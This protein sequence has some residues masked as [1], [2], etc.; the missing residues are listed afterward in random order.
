[1]KDRKEKMENRKEKDQRLISR[2]MLCALAAAMALAVGLV[3]RPVSAQA[4]SPSDSGQSLAEVI[5]A[6]E[7]ARV[8]TRILYVTAHPD[9]EPGAVLAYLARGLHAD[10]ALLSLTRGEGGQNALGPEQAPQL[11]ILRTEELMNAT[12]VYGTRLFFTRAADFGYTKSPEEALK[13]WGDETLEDMVRVIR[14]F[15]PHVIINNWGGVR[16]GHGQHVAAGILTPKAYAMAADAKAFP[17]LLDEGLQPWK[18]EALLQ[19][20]RGG[21]ASG[22]FSIPVG[23]VSALWGKSWGE[24]GVEGYLN[25][26]TQGVGGVRNSPFFR[27]AF[28]VMAVEGAKPDAALLG[29]PL[30]AMGKRLPDVD[31]AGFASLMKKVDEALSKA[32]LSAR[33]LD[34]KTATQE[35]ARAAHTLESSPFDMGPQNGPTKEIAMRELQEVRER[36]HTALGAAAGLYVE[37]TADRADV[38]AGESFTVT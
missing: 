28:A 33:E 13:V 6:I 32:A 25:H 38:V 17:K 37:A 23:E 10:V 8:T 36:I 12:R 29:A 18:A 21:D 34:W 24:I 16:G 26:R 2:V 15:R 11:G 7:K 30:S 5:E 1:M 19:P 4:P 22:G 27:R 14:T 31:D 3:M 35:L 20:A 9:D